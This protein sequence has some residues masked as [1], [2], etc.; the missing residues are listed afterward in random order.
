MIYIVTNLY[1]RFTS[2]I[3]YL[4]FNRL[5][6]ALMKNFNQ[7]NC[8]PILNRKSINQFVD[9]HKWCVKSDKIEYF[10]FDYNF[11]LINGAV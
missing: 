3:I 8:Y 1:Q 7:I 9:L 10:S 5:G 2:K 6:W 11:I 4:F